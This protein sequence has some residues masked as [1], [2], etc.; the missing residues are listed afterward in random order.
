MAGMPRSVWKGTLSF[1]LVAIPVSLFP[2]TESK[3]VRFHLFDREGR[4]VRY[5]RVVDAGPSLG[6]APDEAEV[7]AAEVDDAEEG[8]RPEPVRE[9]GPER[10]EERAGEVEVAYE[11][12]VRGYEVEP[13]S[14]VFLEPGEIERARPTPS[15][16]IDLELFVRLEE[17]DPVFFEKSYHVVPASGAEKP[18]ALLLRTLTES[19][20]VGI[21]R[22]VLRTKPHLVALRPRDEA[23]ALETLFFGDEVREAPASVRDLARTSVNKRELDVSIQL[24]EALAAEWEPSI[25]AD[26]YREELLR[27]IAERTP[28]RIEE[29]DEPPPGESRVG[30][31]LEA[32]R[33]SVAEAKA[34]GPRKRGRQAG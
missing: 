23:L 15:S 11:D 5:R 14:F 33:R 17:I 18:Y 29:P 1:G 22:F 3:D 28:E 30:E 21:G 8:D 4:R 27:M 2:A 26:E 25:F 6:A 20:R 16:A 9:V 19:G 10:G 13:E 31:L 24:V 32:L 12:L 34:Q 7:D